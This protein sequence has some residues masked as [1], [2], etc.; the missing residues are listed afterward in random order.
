MSGEKGVLPSYTIN[1]QSQTMIKMLLVL[2]SLLTMLQEKEER[3][4]QWTERGRQMDRK[5]HRHTERQRKIDKQTEENG[6]HR[7]RKRIIDEN[8]KTLTV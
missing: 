8:C 5:R 2:M 6:V 7:G 4:R 1:I 3:E